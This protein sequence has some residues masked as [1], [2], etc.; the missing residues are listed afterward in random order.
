[1]E[2]EDE[3][4]WNRLL[5]WKERKRKQEQEN[6]DKQADDDKIGKEEQELIS[7]NWRSKLAKQKAEKKQRR[8]S[9][10]SGRGEG[11]QEWSGEMASQ[12]IEYK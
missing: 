2:N 3:E 4:R 6:R 11:R 7:D 8:H 5:L 12:P 10:G 9:L 1:M